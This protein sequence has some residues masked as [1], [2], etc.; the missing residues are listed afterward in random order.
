MRGGF[1]LC[2]VMHRNRGWILF[3]YPLSF[4][5][6]HPLSVVGRGGRGGPLCGGKKRESN[7]KA[8]WVELINTRNGRADE[9]NNE[10]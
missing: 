8:E 1:S 4:A 6:H 5:F 2:T 9:E 3:L 10:S 7:L